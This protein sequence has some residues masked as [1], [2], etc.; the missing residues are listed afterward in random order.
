D[1]NDDGM[2]DDKT[3]EIVERKDDT[4]VVT[5]S[6]TDPDAG[7]FVKGEHERQFAYVDQVACDRHGWILT[8]VQEERNSFLGTSPKMEPSNT[9][10]TKMNVELVLINLFA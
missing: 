6:T 9:R 4:K 3:G 1:S 10:F 8:F 7:M 2:I 5:L